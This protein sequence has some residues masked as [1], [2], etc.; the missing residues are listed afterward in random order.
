MRRETKEALI[1]LRL[2]E[3]ARMCAFACSSLDEVMETLEKY[4][5]G[6]MAKIDDDEKFREW[7]RGAFG[8]KLA[9]TLLEKDRSYEEMKEIIVRARL[10]AAKELA[11]RGAKITL[12]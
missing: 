12:V 7:A 1:K 11:S 8:P 2:S 4:Y 10:D 6:V 5:E 3:V 9:E